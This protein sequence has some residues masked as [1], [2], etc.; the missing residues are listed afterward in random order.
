MVWTFWQAFRPWASRAALIITLGTAALA[1]H[2]QYYAESN[3]LTVFLAYLPVWVMA[4]PLAVAL[5]VAGMFAC[6][7]AALLCVVTA[8]GIVTWLGGHH[9]PGRAVSAGKGGDTISVLGYN[10]GQGSEKVLSAFAE[11]VRPDIVVFQDAARRLP[12]LMALPQF[13]SHSFNSSHGE[14]VLL[15]CW[16]VLESQPLFLK[17]AGSPKGGCQGGVRSVIDWNG[18]RVVVYNIHLPTPRDLLSWYSRRG[19]F[20]YGILGLVPHTPFYI[21][22][23][24]YLAIWTSRVGLMEQLAERIRSEVDPVVLLGDLNMPPVGKAYHLLST[25][26]Q[27]AHAEAGSGFGHTFPGNMTSIL[28]RFSPWIRIDHVFA[29]RQWEIVSSHVSPA[30]K[31]Q[32]LPVAVSLRLP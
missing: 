22:H 10:R 12:Q 6:W 32:H 2:I 26:L 11:Q 21:R 13:A 30:G 9:F 31:S 4:L 14:Y 19:T 28:Q 3:L 16:P 8:V 5:A 1:F 24:E 17:W 7:R 18:R 20:L 23:Q 15:S 27:D 29:S 25:L